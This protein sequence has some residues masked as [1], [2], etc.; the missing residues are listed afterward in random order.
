MPINN[1]A[2]RVH[3][4]YIRAGG[5]SFVSAFYKRLMETSDDI[6]KRFEHIDMESQADTLAHAIVMSFLF[7]DKNHESATRCLNNVRESHSR[8][9]LN[10]PP[11]LYDV[12]LEC[13]IETVGACDPHAND[14]LLTDWHEVMSMAITHIREGY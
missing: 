1:K 14:Q 8:H 4:S 11:H 12:W 9:N 5:K 13:M 3:E 6:K 2:K 10:I 7:V